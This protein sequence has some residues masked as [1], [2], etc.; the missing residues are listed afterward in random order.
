MGCG[1]PS[2]TRVYESTGDIVK[3]ADHLQHE[4]VKTLVGYAE[5][6]EGASQEVIKEW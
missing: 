4:N 1:T 6:H 5:R 2:G 3:V